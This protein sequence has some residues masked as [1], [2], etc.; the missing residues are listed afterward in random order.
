MR[1]AIFIGGIFIGD[2]FLGGNFS[3]TAKIIKKDFKAKTL[4]YNVIFYQILMLFTFL[5]ISYV[6]G[7]PPN[8]S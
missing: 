3:E 4:L 6:L 1:G 5:Q 2:N 8:T 7:G